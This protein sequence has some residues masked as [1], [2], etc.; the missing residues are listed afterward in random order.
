MISG[1]LNDATAKQIEVLDISGRTLQFHSLEISTTKTFETK[2]NVSEL[3]AGIYYL[4][5]STDKGK[6]TR[7]FVKE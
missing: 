2:I 7:P 1:T 6:I 5:L 3:A 4:Q